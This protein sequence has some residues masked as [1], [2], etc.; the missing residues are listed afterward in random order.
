MPPQP[1]RMQCDWIMTPATS[2]PYIHCM[3]CFISCVVPISALPYN[4]LLPPLYVLS[5]DGHFHFSVPPNILLFLLFPHDDGND[6]CA[7]AHSPITNTRSIG[8]PLLILS[9]YLSQMP[10]IKSTAA[11]QY[12]ITSYAHP[13]II[14]N[15]HRRTVVVNHSIAIKH[16]SKR[17]SH[18]FI[19]I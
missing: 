8:R 6:I 2:L 4:E 10:C 12:L 17:Y 19:S 18:L 7:T 14:V 15:H 9:A 16:T 11:N 3:P 13:S 1:R 5:R